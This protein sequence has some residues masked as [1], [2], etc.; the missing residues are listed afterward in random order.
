LHIVVLIIPLFTLYLGTWQVRR[1]RW[2]VALIE[3]VERNLEKE[4]MILPKRVK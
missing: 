4:P 3:E 1:L 2:K